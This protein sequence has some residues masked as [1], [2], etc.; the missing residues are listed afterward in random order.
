VP[1]YLT[2]TE[3]GK[4][5]LS[6]WAVSKTL[7]EAADLDGNRQIDFHEWV[8][9]DTLLHLPLES[10][11][12]TFRAMDADSSGSLDA[13]EF[14]QVLQTVT[15][16]TMLTQRP[17]IKS[18]F[19][20]DGRRKVSL[21][22]FKAWYTRLKREVALLEFQLMDADGNGR[23]SAAEFGSSIVAYN[24]AHYGAALAELRDED[25]EVSFE[26]YWAYQRVAEQ[27]DRVDEAI[28]L[29]LSTA[30][31]GSVSRTHFKRAVQAVTDVPLSEVVVETLFVLFNNSSG[32][33]DTSRMTV[34]L[35]NRAAGGALASSP[36]VFQCFANCFESEI[37][38]RESVKIKD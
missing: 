8:F 6:K 22:T 2:Q 26:E 31:D 17:R 10:I 37:V 38:R 24:S 28:R 15:G 25:G 36:S 30:R 20:S 7:C 1:D 14:L 12:V 16:N 32:R 35:R 11:E 13:D 4:A 23:V 9:F 33:L 3:H 27:M 34:E 5:R 19:G 21:A 18:L 29:F